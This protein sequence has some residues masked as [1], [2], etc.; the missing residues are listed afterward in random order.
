MF[1]RETFS[2]VVVAAVVQDADQELILFTILLPTKR[3]GRRKDQYGFR[4]QS[5]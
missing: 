3:E 4:V 1:V 5:E 2:Q